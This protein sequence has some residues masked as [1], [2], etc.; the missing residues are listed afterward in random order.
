PSTP[1]YTL[2]GLSVAALIA[3]SLIPQL[4][5]LATTGVGSVSAD[6]VAIATVLLKIYTK[7]NQINAGLDFWGNYAHAI[8]IWPF[9]YLQ[10]VATNFAQLAM[11]AEQEVINFWSQADQGTLTQTQLQNQ[12]SQTN[13]QVD[14][15]SQQFTQAQDQAAAYQ[16]GATLAQ[17]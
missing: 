4:A 13:A 14:V 6:D 8:P 1:L 9:S 17:S 7:L 3:T 11:G 12:V 2:S 16:A 15:A 10:Q 5:T